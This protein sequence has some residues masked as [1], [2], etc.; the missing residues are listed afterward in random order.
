MISFNGS[1]NQTQITVAEQANKAT[2]A[3]HK[4]LDD[5]RN[6][7]PHEMTTLFDRY[8]SPILNYGCEVWGF[9]KPPNIERVHLNFL[10]ENSSG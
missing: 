10:Q 3:L 7:Y 6:T 4:R 5:F 1:F 9:H 2:F 8:I